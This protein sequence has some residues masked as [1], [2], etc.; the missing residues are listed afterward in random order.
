VV[1]G[2]VSILILA[3]LLGSGCGEQGKEEGLARTDRAGALPGGSSVQLEGA[4]QSAPP[5][6]GDDVI[7]K[8]NGNDVTRKDLEKEVG[9]IVKQLGP[10]ASP[11]FI[12]QNRA[13]LEDRAFQSLVLKAQLAVYAGEQ[14]VEVTDEEINERMTEF[15]TNIGGEDALEEAMGRMGLDRQSL[16]QDIREGMLLE[17]AVEQYRD[18]LPEP[19][20]QAVESFYAENQDKFQLPDQVTASHILIGVEPGDSP[21]DRAVKQARAES[22]R[23]QLIEGAD[24]AQLALENST[25]PSKEEGGSLG[26]FGKGAMVPAFDKAVFA[27]EAGELSP[28]VETQFGYHVIRVT[29]QQKAHLATLE[30]AREAIVKDLTDTSIGSWFEELVGRA[31]VEKN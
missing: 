20:T 15:A 31:E 4:G 10:G 27:L 24:F 18:T 3:G 14:K 9:Y 19:D 8:I 16:R 11:G 29:E 21:E 13:Q 30:E 1:R 23:Q 12:Q 7:G 6:K 22:V 5:R 2:G 25:C 17:R 28:V 26:T